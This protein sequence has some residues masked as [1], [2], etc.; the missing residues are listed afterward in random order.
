MALSLAIENAAALALDER[1][2]FLKSDWLDA[3]PK[4][5]P[6]DLIVSNPPY[7]KLRDLETAEPEVNQFEPKTALVSEDEGVF[8]LKKIIEKA[9]FFIAEN[10]WLVVET[11]INQKEALDKPCACYRVSKSKHEKDLLIS[12]SLLM[13]ANLRASRAFF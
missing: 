5:N 7:L 4:E 3:V 6:Y 2:D 8:D 11:G 13:H 12:K 1:V 9:P 10:G